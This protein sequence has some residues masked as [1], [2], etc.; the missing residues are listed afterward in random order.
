M[1]EQDIQKTR[2]A[3]R[4]HNESRPQRVQPTHLD[5]CDEAI[6]DPRRSRILPY[7]TPQT[8]P[9]RR[10]IALPIAPAWPL[11]RAERL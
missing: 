7:E 11:D 6:L 1:V 10:L 9:V 2:R 3:F 8:T 4:H 5:I